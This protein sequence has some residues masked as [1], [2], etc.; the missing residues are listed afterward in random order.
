M[1]MSNELVTIRFNMKKLCGILL[2]L[3]I[4]LKTEDDN[5]DSWT[6]E[7]STYTSVF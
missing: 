1:S 7:K 3:N 6:W 2:F 4:E 5:F